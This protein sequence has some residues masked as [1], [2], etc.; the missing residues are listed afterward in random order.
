MRCANSRTHARTHSRRLRFCPLV[1]QFEWKP[2]LRRLCLANWLSSLPL[3]WLGRTTVMLVWQ[4]CRTA[5]SAVF[6][7]SSTLQLGWSLDFDDQITSLTLWR[8][9]AS[10]HW[11]RASQ[12]IKFKLAVLVYRALHGTATSLLDVRPSHRATVANRSFTTARTLLN[13]A[14]YVLSSLT[15]QLMSHDETNK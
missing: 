11:L 9:L 10:F 2:Y 3:F 15:L 6:S 13:T 4:V 7:R 5:Y 12:R 1:S 8:R 14:T